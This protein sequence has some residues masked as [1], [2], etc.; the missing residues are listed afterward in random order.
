MKDR[1]ALIRPPFL[2]LIIHADDFDALVTVFDGVIA[3]DE[4]PVE[5]VDQ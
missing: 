1:A 4:K 3:P 2:L 5:E